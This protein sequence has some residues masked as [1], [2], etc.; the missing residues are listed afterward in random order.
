QGCGLGTFGA[1]RQRRVTPSELSAK[2]MR[3]LVTRPE[4]DASLMAQELRELGCEAVLQPLLEFRSLNFDARPLETAAA[5]IITSANAVR[6]LQEKF[7]IEAIAHTPLFCT[8][9]ETAR[10]ASQGVFRS[11][12]ATAGTAS[13]LSAKIVQAPGK[14]GT[15]VHV[16]GEHQAFDLAGALSRDGLSLHTLCVY[17]MVPR[18][19]F[20]AHL[21]DEIKSSGIGGVILMSPRTAK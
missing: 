19:S 16:T 2:P 3:L 14:D 12:A 20:E 9:E 18:L 4:P 8:G 15:L 21:I 1:W 7:K 17:N 5:L 11:L 10:P 6:A 13:E